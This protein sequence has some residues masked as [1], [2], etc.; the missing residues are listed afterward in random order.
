MHIR[1]TCAGLLAASLMMGGC[2]PVEEASPPE[3]LEKPAGTPAN[4]VMI[5]IDTVRYD[6]ILGRTVDDELSAYLGQAL[7][8]ANA[9]S[10]APWTMPSVSSMLT[11]LYPQQHGAGKFPDT[12]ANLDLQVPSALSE[13]ALT[14]PEI[15]QEQ[16]FD[17]AAFVSHPFFTSELGLNQGFDQLHSRKGWNKDVERMWEWHAKRKPEQRWFG[18]LHFMEAHDWH[19]RSRGELKKR[20]DQ[21]SAVELEEL[22][23]LYPHNCTKAPNSLRC[24]KSVVYELSVLEMRR[25]IAAILAG[26][27]QRGALED[28]VVVVYADHGEEFWEHEAIQV[29]RDEDPRNFRGIGHGQTL[30]QEQLHIPLLAWHPGLPGR[31]IEANVSLVDVLPSVLNWLQ[32]E[33]PDVEFAGRPMP[34][35]GAPRAS[36]DELF[37]SGIAYGPQQV[38]VR[39]G[40]MK[41][42]F[43]LTREE[44][45]IYNLALDPAELNPLQDQGL[46]FEFGTLTG[47][48]LEL[49]AR[50]TGAT[51]ELSAAQ[52]EDLKAIG[53]LQGVEESAPPPTPAK[54][55]EQPEPQAEQP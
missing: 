1:Y 17:T 37:A 27:E 28:T 7:H 39:K 12:V 54:P 35:T 5:C 8:Y 42:I 11:G 10:T 3:Q 43:S 46:G 23:A 2:K 6:S 34:P 50:Y 38:A 18:Y 20:V 33:Q 4:L 13:D 44:L 32:L 25:A 15:L 40:A 29:E 21:V 36:E 26:L 9:S 49:P 53:Y 30:F 24:L 51:G 31:V 19:T 41:S 55:D 22:R 48:Y 14:L 47:D 45:E 52:I 16:G